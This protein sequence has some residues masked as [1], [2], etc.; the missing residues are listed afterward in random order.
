MSQT[1]EGTESFFFAFLH[2]MK[3][4]ERWG[5]M[6]NTESEN[7]QEHSL[8]VA[9][10]AH[11][12]ACMRNTYFGGS[13]DSN[14]VAVMAMFHEVSEI[15]TGDMPTPIKYF[16]PK[17][18]NL[19]GEIEELAQDKMLR[20]LPEELQPLYKPYIR[21]A[22]SSDLWPLVKAA[23]MLAAYMKTIYEVHAGNEEFRAARDS[24]RNKLEGLHMPEVDK[25]LDDYVPSLT[26]SL[27]ELN[28]Y[29]IKG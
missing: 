11:N 25:F 12:L 6:R 21:D 26:K 16:T 22:E 28:Y 3:Y 17:L 7:I 13:V 18:R 19:Y 10:I 15:F 1:Q 27:D 4:I 5:L 29:Q 9:M 2:R 8:E 23:D 24:I 14:Q 20:T